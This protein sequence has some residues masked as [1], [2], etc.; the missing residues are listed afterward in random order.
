MLPDL[1]GIEVCR[2]M[3]QERVGA[4]ILVLTAKD[5]VPDRIGGLRAGADDYLT[6]PFAFDEFVARAE[7]LLRRGEMRRREDRLQV[8]G[9]TPDPATR[10][11]RRG[12]RPIA[13]TPKEHA[14]LRHLMENARAV[15]SRAQLLDAIRGC[16]FDPGTRVVE[17]DLRCLR[18]K[19]DDGAAEPLIRTWRGMGSCIGP[20]DGGEDGGEEAEDGA[21]G[22]D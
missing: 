21:A 17:V 3:R 12:G 10:Q 15:Q 4:R 6:G 2:Q 1:D 11:V 5:A 18:A 20:P 9:L 13:L 22:E 14:L 7:A 16:G 19:V 8:G